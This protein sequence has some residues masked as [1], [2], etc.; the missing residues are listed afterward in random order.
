[1]Q[2]DPAVSSWIE[3]VLR[4]SHVAFAFAW[5]GFGWFFVWI[6]APAVSKL[7]GPAR[8]EAAPLLLGRGLRWLGWS[9]VFGWITGLFLLVFLYYF[10]FSAAMFEAGGRHDTTV[11]TAILVAALVLV[12][13]YDLLLRLIPSRIAGT[14]VAILLLLGIYLAMEKIGN[15][16]GR[17]L[18]IHTGAILGSAIALNAMMR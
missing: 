1:M 3:L 4:W 9:A 5:V 17:A 10:R 7:S 11:A 18:Y 6:A 13:V 14:S 15:F 2:M 12:Y 16:N 8:N